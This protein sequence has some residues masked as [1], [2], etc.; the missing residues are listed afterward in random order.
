VSKSCPIPGHH[1]LRPTTQDH[2]ALVSVP[3]VSAG[4]HPGRAVAGALDVIP[5]TRVVHCGRIGSI[6]KTALVQRKRTSCLLHRPGRDTWRIALLLLALVA[7][8]ASAETF[9]DDFTD[10]IDPANWTF[11]TNQPLYSIDDTN[12]DVR[13]SRPAGGSGGF[14]AANLRFAHDVSGDFDVSVAFRD[15]AITLGSGSPGN[16]VQLNLYFGGQYLGVV[17]SD[18]VGFGNNAHVF[19]DPPGSWVGTIS[20]SVTAGTLRVTRV[21]TTVTCMIDSTTLFS[22]TLNGDDVTDIWLSLQNNGTIDATSV[23]F[24]DFSLVADSILFTPV[25]PALSRGATLL[26]LAALVGLGALAL[27]R[28]QRPAR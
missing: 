19:P 8:R 9:S 28:G 20:T 13:I 17:R 15:A 7:G 1:F 21:G 18:E 24:D 14:Q 2:P 25:V 12:G 26:L 6:L 4:C 16:Q 11:D 3:I 23:T 10:G 27:H 5:R 22:G